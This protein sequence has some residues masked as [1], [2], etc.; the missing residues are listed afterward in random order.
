IPEKSGMDATLC[1]PPPVAPSLPCPACGGRSARGRGTTSCPKANGATAAANMPKKKCRS[2]F[3]LPSYWVMAGLVP[4]NPITSA[5]RP[6]VQDRRDK[7]AHP[8]RVGHGRD[9]P[10]HDPIGG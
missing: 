2:T 4:A 5:L 8:P 9:E 7:R 10:G 6:L 1:G 3:M